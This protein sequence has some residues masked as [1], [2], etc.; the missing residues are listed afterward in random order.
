VRT[1]LLDNYDSF[2]FNLF[3]LLAETNGEDPVVVRND[4]ATWGDLARESFDNIVISPG[5]GRPERQA[6]FGVCRDAVD[7]AR[8]PI[9]GVCLGHQGLAYFSGGSVIHAPEVMHGRLSAVYHDR[10]PL[11][12]G[13]PQGFQA[14]RYHSLCVARPLPDW[15]V[16]IAWTD[17]GVLMGVAHRRR[18]QWGVQF[19][20]ES[21][22]T[23]HGR[24]LLENFRDLTR[25]GRR[26]KRQ[27]PPTACVVP[28]STGSD[29]A[30]DRDLTLVVE[31]VD[32]LYDT[33][34]AFVH[35]YGGAPDAF[36]LDSSMVADERSRF[37]FMGAAGGPLSAV[38]RY[39]VERRQVVVRHGTT[40]EAHDETIFDHLRRELRRMRHLADDLP[41]DLNCGFV[42][43]FGYEL[44][45]DCEG[46]AA[47]RSPLPD[48]AF[49]FADRL[50][51]FDHVAE[52]TYVLCLVTPSYEVEGRRWV[53]D[54]RRR[55][56]DLPP[57]PNPPRT[58]RRE[59]VEFRLSRSYEQYIQ[60]IRRC[61]EHLVE[62]ETYEVCLTNR[63]T[64]DATPDPLATYR[65]LRHV[66]PAPFSA[67]LRFG[68]AAVLS[69]S[70][71]RFLRVGRDRWVEAKP[72]KGTVRRGSTP[73][74]DLEL[75]EGLRTS[76]KNQAENLMITDLL[77]NDL[78]LVCEIGTVQ[79]PR[80][81]AIESFET[82]HQLVSTVSGRL[83]EDLSPADCIRACFPGG[84]MTGAPKK[85]TMQIIDELEQQPRGVYSGAI[86]YLG[87]SGGS[88]LNIVI[89]TIVI[90]G[91][92]CSIGAGG[93]IVMQSD[94]DD[95]FQEMLL[96]AEALV[97][98]IAL[99]TGA[100][101]AP[102]VG[103][104]ED[105]RRLAHAVAHA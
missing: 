71:E 73:A 83:R 96:K 61:Q 77:R 29:P 80:L 68:D 91:E 10:S 92:S 5:P 48:A 45:A 28:R 36:W 31:R 102:I 4:G 81:M 43:Y 26:R 6:D 101:T 94:P 64:T 40:T 104:V 7:A 18:P 56:D 13:I 62:G 14:V 69:S 15:L 78:G 24:R 65:I 30:P 49:V 20:P 95:E 50:I 11:F 39:D 41:F 38:L 51:A 74:E 103:P 60:D 33:E 105:E 2:T 47:H 46:D 98:A 59:S 82:V 72:I 25:N 70:P 97:K 27:P 100:E 32:R 53:R 99:S 35:L 42:G 89:R 85:R 17:D 23:E 9:L 57:L 76:E 52:T 67:F 58:Q 93:A 3:Q 54:T 55:L 37:S 21:I 90:D 63:L 88:D 75:S 66:N 8:I 19:H 16:P 22:C 44:K 34:S 86:G 1:L 79:V 12:A 84:S 87:L